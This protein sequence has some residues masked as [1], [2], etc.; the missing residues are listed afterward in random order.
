VPP[1]APQGIPPDWEQCPDSYWEILSALELGEQ[2]G[3]R[4]AIVG[5]GRESWFYPPGVRALVRSWL[6]QPEGERDRTELETKLRE[7]T[8]ADAL[9]QRRRK[10]GISD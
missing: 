2:V 3:R 7:L 4:A 1:Y 8:W 6:V 9:K 5:P 10:A